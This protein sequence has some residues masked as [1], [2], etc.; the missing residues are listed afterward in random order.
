MTEAG[1]DHSTVRDS[2]A[3]GLEA[4]I[5]E[6]PSLQQLRKQP[7]TPLIMEWLLE[8]REPHLMI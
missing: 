6:R 8:D 5:L 2:T 3:R 7:E 4:P 1:A